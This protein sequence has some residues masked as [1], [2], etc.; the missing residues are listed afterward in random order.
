MTE[1]SLELPIDT[2]LYKTRDGQT[3]IVTDTGSFAY[4][5]IGGTQ[6]FWCLDSGDCLE[7]T[8]PGPD[9]R[10]LVSQ[11]KTLSPGFNALNEV[12]SHGRS[13]GRLS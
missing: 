6:E 13:H 1:D 9:P 5:R 8:R 2:G 7:V 3:A 4:G 10:D 11:I 12:A